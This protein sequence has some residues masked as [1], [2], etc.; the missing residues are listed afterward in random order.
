MKSP[1]PKP[2][3]SVSIVFSSKGNCF[4]SAP[5]NNIQLTMNHISWTNESIEEF[6]EGTLVWARIDQPVD[7]TELQK[8]LVACVNAYDEY[9]AQELSPELVE[10]ELDMFTRRAETY[11]V[12]EV[13][14]TFDLEKFVA[15][16]FPELSKKLQTVMVLR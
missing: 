3:N 10:G 6:C 13:E 7:M 8:R 4:M 12:R 1:P 16:E 9:C 11:T 15:D 14:H 5:T 2:N